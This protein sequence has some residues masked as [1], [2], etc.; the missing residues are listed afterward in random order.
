VGAFMALNIDY[1]MWKSISSNGWEYF[2]C[3]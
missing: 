2:D 1:V 3:V